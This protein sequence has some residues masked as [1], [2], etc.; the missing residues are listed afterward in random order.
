MK[1]IASLKEKVKY[2][3]DFHQNKIYCCATKKKRWRDIDTTVVR[4]F[5]SVE[6]EKWTQEDDEKKKK[7]NSI[8]TDKNHEKLQLD[9]IAFATKTKENKGKK[10]RIKPSIDIDEWF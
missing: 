8:S 6:G 10:I 2:D 1:F 5:N 4:R 7:R 9:F 3:W